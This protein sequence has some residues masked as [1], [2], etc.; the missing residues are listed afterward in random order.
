MATRTQGLFKAVRPSGLTRNGLDWNVLSGTV[1]RADH[2]VADDDHGGVCP[3]HEGDGISIAK[4]WR[5]A[6]MAGFATLRCCTVMVDEADVLAEDDNKIRVRAVTVGEWFD[7][8]K[9]IRQGWCYGANLAGANLYG[10][11][12]YG[13][14]LA[15]ADLARA[16][17]YGAD[18]ARADLYRANLAGANL[19]GANLAGANLAGANLAGWERGPDGYAQRKSVG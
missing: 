11:N 15:R 3:K 6:A 10:A 9:L 1:V 16:N 13:A 14:D 2:N 12:L 8:T 19:Y 5:G 4:T 17:L 7:A 18:L